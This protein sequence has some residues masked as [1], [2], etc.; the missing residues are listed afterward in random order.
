M[1][2]ALLA[3]PRFAGAPALAQQP[4]VAVPEAAQAGDRAGRRP[5]Q[6]ADRLRRRSLPA[7]RAIPTR[8]PSARGCPRTT[9]SGSR[10]TCATIPTIRPTRAGPIARSSS[11]MSAAAAPT[12]ARPTGA[13]GFTGCFNQI[14]NQARAE[15]RDSRRRQ[16]GA[17]DRGGAAGAAAAGSTPPTQEEEAERPP[18]SRGRESARLMTRRGARPALRRDIGFTGS[19]FLSFSGMVGA[20]IFALPGDAPQPV[21]RVQ[22][23]AVPDLRP[24]LPADRPAVRAAGGAAPGLGRPGRLYR[25]VRAA[26]LLPGRLALLCRA[27][28][29]AR[30]QRQRLRHLRRLALA[31]AR[32]HGRPGGDDRRCW[33]A[34]SPGSTWSASAARSARSTC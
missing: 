23:L 2:I 34:R 17:A 20:G 11:P 4:G 9:A 31:A 7:E 28:H 12:A 19:A 16:L 29:R 10:R 13:G 25:A 6:P 18:R 14:V 22:P 24:A 5:G 1:R 30:R 8:S 33:S 32:R 3:L 15:R 21:R 27:D 26:R